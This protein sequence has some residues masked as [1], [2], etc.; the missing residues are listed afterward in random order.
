MEAKDV[1]LALLVGNQQGWKRDPGLRYVVSGDLQPM[2]K[3]LK[4]AGFEVHKVLVN[5]SPDSLRRVLRKLLER[6]RRKPFITTFFFYYSGHADKVHF[7]M[8]PKGKSPFSYR[9]FVKFL[10]ALQVQRRFVIIDACFSGEVI[11]QFGNLG[12]YRKLLHKGILQKGVMRTLNKHDL[13]QHIPKRGHRVQGLE[14]LSSSQHLSFESEKLKGSVF[15]H[16]LLQGLR[17]KADLNQDGQIS[18]SELFMYTR[19]KVHAYTGQSPQQWLFRV[20]GAAYGFVPVYKSQLQIEASVLGHLRIHVKNFVWRYNK[21]KKQGVKLSVVSGRGEVTLRRGQRCYRQSMHFPT[22]GRAVLRTKGW[23]KQSCFK[24]RWLSKGHV[25]IQAYQVPYRPVESVLFEV[26]AGGFGSTGA[27]KNGG[28]LSGSGLLGLRWRHWA[29]LLGVWGTSL[30]FADVGH[31]QL[32]LELRFEGGFRRKWERWGLF[33]GGYLSTSFLLQDV[34]QA[35]KTS[36]LLQVGGTVT[37]AF[38]LT[39]ETALLLSVDVGL[40]PTR[41]GDGWRFFL[42]GGVRLGLRFYFS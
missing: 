40:L 10:S 17:G 31:H 20:G 14:L 5:R 9:E 21:R 3:V 28:D 19:P 36:W 12:R 33:A 42:T 2:Q 27:L 11:R 41:M 16:Y 37:P 13:S 15:T 4:R 34:N 6:S 22:D 24:K 1:R 30:Q 35:I 38:W 32:G 7:H 25:E 26:Q 18:F 39:R 23:R 29:A 8:G